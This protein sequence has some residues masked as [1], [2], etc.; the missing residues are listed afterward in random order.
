MSII[1]SPLPPPQYLCPICFSKG[2][3]LFSF[4]VKPLREEFKTQ[5]FQIWLW[6]VQ[7]EAKQITH[8]YSSSERPLW[9]IFS[10]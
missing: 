4:I 10:S 7:H 8:L 2:T 5:E 3:L 1:H 9:E 6:G